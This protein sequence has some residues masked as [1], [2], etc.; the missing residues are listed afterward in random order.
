[1]TA[2]EKADARAQCTMLHAP[3]STIFPFATLSLNIAQRSNIVSSHALH[4]RSP[5]TTA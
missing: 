2:A 3:N 1:M 5:L 4:V